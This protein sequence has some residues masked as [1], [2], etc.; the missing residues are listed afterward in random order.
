MLTRILIN[1]GALG[2]D[3]HAQAFDTNIPFAGDV[4]GPIV[5]RRSYPHGDSDVD[6]RSMLSELKEKG[7]MPHAFVIVRDAIPSTNAQAQA[8]CLST[9]VHWR[10]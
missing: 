8:P 3:T 6:L 1:F 7:W 4:S 5:W 9:K 10:P 2:E